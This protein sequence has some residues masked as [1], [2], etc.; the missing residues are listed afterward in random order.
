MGGLM[1]ATALQQQQL[2]GSDGATGTETPK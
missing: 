1:G 2:T